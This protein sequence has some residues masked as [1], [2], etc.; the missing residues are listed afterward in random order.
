[1]SMSALPDNATQAEL[2]GAC[3]EIELDKLFAVA[4]TSPADR[5]HFF[6]RTRRDDDGVE[7]IVDTFADS[8][9]RCA[10]LRCAAGQSIRLK[11]SGPHRISVCAGGGWLVTPE[12]AEHDTVFWIPQA[13]RLRRLD[14]DGH[15]RFHAPASLESVTANAR[16]LSVSLGAVD[17]AGIDVVAWRLPSAIASGLESLNAIEM[18][19]VFLWSSHT[20]YTRPADVFLHLIHGHVY[21][22]HE[23]DPFLGQVERIL[24][25]ISW[26]SDL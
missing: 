11:V 1:M 23:V 21:E 8:D 2:Q 25:R 22:N 24:L 16:E 17:D 9:A 19:P 14:A 10:F 20:R 18:A 26:R 7:R 13:P 12:Q 3:R 5:E 15:I 4:S 6:H